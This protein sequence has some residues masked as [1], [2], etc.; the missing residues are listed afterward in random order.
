MG[1]KKYDYSDE[2]LLDIIIK[3][4]DKLGRPPRKIDMGSANNVPS[5]AFYYKRFNTTKWSDILNMCGLKQIKKIYSKEDGLKKLKQYYEKINKVPTY[6]DFKKYNWSPCFDWYAIH[7]DTYKNA[8]YLAGLSNNKPLSKNE[9]KQ[10]TIDE[11]NE[12][13]KKI[14]KPPTKKEYNQFRQNG[15]SS[16]RIRDIFGM[17]YADFRSNYIKNYYDK[18]DIT[19]EGYKNLIQQCSKNLG[20]TPTCEEVGYS[21]SFLI[22]NFN[23]TY[24]QILDEM[25]VTPY[26]YNYI[27]DSELLNDFYLL[28]KKLGY[29]PSYDDL[30]N[31]GITCNGVT[32]NRR[33]GG[34][35]KTCELLN[36]EYNRFYGTGVVCYDNNGNLCNSAKEKDISNFFIK[37]NIKYIKEVGYNELIKNDRR[38]FDWK[39]CL[40]DKIYYVEYFG[41]YDINK[42]N[43]I[44]VNSYI[45]KARKKIKDLYKARVIDKCIF[46]FPY[47]LNRLDE[48]FNRK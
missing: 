17:S 43:N 39:V 5:T 9:R 6:N 27:D 16:N 47:D 44:I 11:I 40:N 1:K 3:L 37:N 30:D 15:Y 32:Y 48:I 7:F 33:F 24:L 21:F 34:I 14:N 42:N 38:V 12:L 4:N 20:R 13:Y 23:K 18:Y 29:I 8:C 26:Q 10:A 46:I 2:E 28:Y 45:K 31:S 19:I 22:D 36:I 35:K 25:G 41:L